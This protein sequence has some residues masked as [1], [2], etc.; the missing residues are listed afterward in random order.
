M[1]RNIEADITACKA[2]SHFLEISR[3]ILESDN[4]RYEESHSLTFLSLFPFIV[5]VSVSTAK[6]EDEEGNCLKCSG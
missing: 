3:C 6:K 1:I 5:S 2:F 4:I